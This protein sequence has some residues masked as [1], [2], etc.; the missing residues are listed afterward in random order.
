MPWK[1]ADMSKPYASIT[2]ICVYNKLSVREQCLDRSID[3]L[4]SESDDV[5]Y[6]PVENTN[7]SYSSAGAA[8]NHGVTLAKNDV[9]VFAHQDVYL[10]SLL[11]LKRAAAQMQFERFGVLGSIGIGAD[12]RFYGRMRDRVF[13]T[14]QK[15]ERLTEVDS[16]DEVLFMA[17][18][19]QLLNEPLTEAIDLAWHAY[20]VEYGLRLRRK[21]LRVGVADIPLTH[22]S[23][24]LNTERLNVAHQV[25]ARRYPEF[26]PLNTTCGSITSGISEDGHRVRLS[27]LRRRYRWL[28]DS[29]ALQKIR[30]SVV[31]AAGVLVDLRHDIDGAI[32]RAPGRRLHIVNCTAEGPFTADNLKPV[33]LSRGGGTLI[34]SDGAL[35]DIP[36]IVANTPPNAWVLVANLTEQDIM[37]LMSQ[38]VRTSSVLGFYRDA[39][40]WLLLGPS[41]TELPESWRSKRATPLGP[42]A[43]VGASFLP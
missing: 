7:G 12:G 6:I 25:V 39:G 30:T 31:E 2:I 42:R 20:A 33:E 16:L 1:G 35:S 21:G 26:L 3:A 4:S 43:I 11:A 9:V 18:T 34:F 22:H 8:L 15:V 24:S 37:F 19:G 23:L 5:E 27:A 32:E 41:L 28:R 36:A 29:M 38:I 40:P 17:P 10:H 14:G 13:L